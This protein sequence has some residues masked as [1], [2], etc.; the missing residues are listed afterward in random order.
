LSI[1]AN[2]YSLENKLLLHREEKTDAAADVVTDGFKLELA[3]LLASDGV[4]LVKLELRNSKG[5]TV[6][7]N[8]YWLGAESASYRRLNRLPASSLSVTAESAR[9]GDKMHVR[10]QLRN[11][12]S[13]VSL[14]DK[15]TLLN[16]D[17]SRILPAYFTDN[18]VSLLPGESREIEIAY[19]AKAA[20]GAAQLGIRGWN[21]RKQTVP[22][23]EGK[24]N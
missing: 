15:L 12:G 23:V 21:I 2:V 14:M 22:V 5:E 7:E 4:V 18:Y 19:P 3:P 17:G 20:N 24:A 11:T 6:S 8:F 9:T 10:V 1:V 13:V 16:A